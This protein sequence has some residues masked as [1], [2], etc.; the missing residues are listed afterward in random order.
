MYDPDELDGEQRERKLR[1]K[2]NNMF[3]NFTN[4]MQE[5]AESDSSRRKRLDFDTGF[6]KMAFRGVIKNSMELIYPATECL[7]E[8]TQNPAMVRRPPP[9]GALRVPSLRLAPLALMSRHLHSPSPPLHPHS[10][11]HAGRDRARSL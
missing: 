6:K 7:F 2:L 3:K 11:H 5:A 8:L 1:M 9:F 4:K 10:G